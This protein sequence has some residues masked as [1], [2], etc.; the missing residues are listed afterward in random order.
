MVT[1]TDDVVLLL[2]MATWC[3]AI[4][5]KLGLYYFGK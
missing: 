2:G 3:K 4:D 5:R 1:K